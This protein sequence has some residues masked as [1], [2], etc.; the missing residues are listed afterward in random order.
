[1]GPRVIDV[2]GLLVKKRDHFPG[3][4]CSGKL[5]N[6]SKGDNMNLHFALVQKVVDLRKLGRPWAAS[7]NVHFGHLSPSIQCPGPR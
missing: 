6:K 5:I 4:I 3:F 2:L 1:M 7:Y